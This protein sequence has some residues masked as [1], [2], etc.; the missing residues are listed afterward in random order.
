MSIQAA[1]SRREDVVAKK[2]YPDAAVRFVLDGLEFTVERSHGPVSPQWLQVARWL[3]RHNLE[4]GQ[5]AR[6]FDEGRLPRNIRRALIAVGGPG[7]FNRHVS[8]RDLCDGLRDLAIQRWGWMA[9]HVLRHWG[10]E[11]TADFGRIVFGLIES[12]RLARQPDD[13][14]EDF[15]DVFDFREAF[16]RSFAIRLQPSVT[17]Q[18]AEPRG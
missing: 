10:V 13:R 17:D 5:L 11:S 2:R 16:D 6:L 14:I 1:E 18:A 8:G 12:G 4:I 3:S 9:L 15:D 7:A